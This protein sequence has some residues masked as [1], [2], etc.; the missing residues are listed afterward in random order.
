ML[1][2]ICKAPGCTR[3]VDFYSGNKY[4][5]EHQALEA[6]DKE[7]RFIFNEPDHGQWDEMYNSPKWR[8]LRARQ[9]KEEPYCQICGS[10]ATEVHH[11]T[12]H[13]G[14]WDLFLDPQNIISICH[15]CHMRETH[16]ESDER[17]KQRRN[18]KKKLWY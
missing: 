6:R 17:K 15:D 2:K 9:L 13:R 14:N 12:P 8:E 10:K 7:R 4:C 5:I 3:L 16:K 18:Q 11:L 1:K